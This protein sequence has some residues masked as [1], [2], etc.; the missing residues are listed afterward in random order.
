MPFMTDSDAVLNQIRGRMMHMKSQ[1]VTR[2]HLYSELKKSQI[3]EKD[4]YGMVIIHEYVI[5]RSFTYV[6]T[7]SIPV[8]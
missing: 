5:I 6:L 8:V 1:K 2:L 7:D 3:R 4:Y